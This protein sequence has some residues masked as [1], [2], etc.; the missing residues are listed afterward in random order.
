ML[1][2]SFSGISVAF[3]TLSKRVAALIGNA[4]SLSLLPPAVNCG[5]LLLLSLLASSPT[6]TGV[7]TSDNPNMTITRCSYPWVRDYNYIY[8]DDPCEASKE[9]AMLGAFSF[10]LVTM[11]ILLIL[12]TGYTVNTLKDMAPRAFTDA[13]VRR[14]YQKDVP[15]FRMAVSSTCTYCT[16]RTWDVC[17]FAL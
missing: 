15:V 14:F 16:R 11:N 12:V 6:I 8:V 7:T 13:T 10:L 5:Q 3:A 2:A 1:V 4:I 17:Q 9:F